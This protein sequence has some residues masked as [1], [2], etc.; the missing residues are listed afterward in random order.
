V[1]CGV[2]RTQTNRKPDDG[3]ADF[4]PAVLNRHE[5]K[6]TTVGRNSGHESSRPVWFVHR[7]ETLYLLPG[8]GRESQW[9]RNALQGTT[10]RLSTGKTTRPASVTP[11]T[12]P[13]EV[14]QVVN[15]FR[16]KYGGQQIADLYPKCEWRSRRAPSHEPLVAHAILT[17]APLHLSPTK[18]A[19]A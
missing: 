14:A 15:A 13:Y 6:R 9:Y 4:Q 5:L 11:I 19:P 2:A 8:D 16:D 10:I 7:G 3:S 1:I 18:G 12:N 17:R